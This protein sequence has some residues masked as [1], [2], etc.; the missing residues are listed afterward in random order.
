MNIGTKFLA[1]VLPKWATFRCSF[2]LELSTWKFQQRV[3][4]QSGSGSAVA[5]RR[6][7]GG[8]GIAV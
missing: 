2:N 5:E 7:V 4:C 3:G 6:Q 1:N 8:G